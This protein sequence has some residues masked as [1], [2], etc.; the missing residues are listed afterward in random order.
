VDG[1][2]V[3]IVVFGGC[4]WYY[5]VSCHS[6]RAPFPSTLSAAGEI[7]VAAYPFQQV[8]RILE[9]AGLRRSTKR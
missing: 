1:H 7:I 3:Y 9:F 6:S 5:C 8:P 4:A 2:R